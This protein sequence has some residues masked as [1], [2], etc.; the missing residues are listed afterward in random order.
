MIDFEIDE[1]H[2]AGKEI[3]STDKAP[4]ALGP[5]SQVPCQNLRS[6]LM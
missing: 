4:A 6:A 3:I 2:S 5:Y 1:I